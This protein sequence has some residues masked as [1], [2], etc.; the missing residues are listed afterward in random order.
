MKRD[1]MTARFKRDY[2]ACMAVVLFF[3]IIVAEV[4]IAVWIPLQMR[5]D[6]LWAE[7]IVRLRLL[8]RFDWMRL[9]TSS[10]KS[11]V[12]LTMAEAEAIEAQ[13]NLIAVYLNNNNQGRDLSPEQILELK[14]VLDEIDRQWAKIK[15]GNPYGKALKLNTD[16][17]IKNI[18]EGSI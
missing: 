6:S 15:R 5:H 10:L 12:A 4:S 7:Q 3:A 14:E 13:L 11:D 2:V 8:S 9:S 18:A 16:Q 17:Y 1:M